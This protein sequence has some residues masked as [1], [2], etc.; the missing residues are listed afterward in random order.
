MISAFTN[1]F[2]IP[3]LRQR[4]LFTL[5]MIVIVRAGSAITTPGVNAE[6][7]REWFRNVADA[8]SAGGVA[9]LFNL[10]SGGALAHCAIFSL[11]IMPYISASIMMQL[12]TAVIPQLGKL[13][14]EDGGRR[15]IMQYTR[16][17]TIAL[18]I[19][20][21]FLLAKSFENPQA[22]PFL[23][24]IMDT[25]NRL[26]MDL[27]PEPGLAFQLMTVITMTAG[28]MFLMWLGDQI[29]ER[30]IGNGVSLI[31]TVG[32]LAQLPAGL[33]QAWRTFVPTAPGAQANVSPIVLVLLCLFL[34]LVIAA[35]IAVTQAQRKISIQYAK[36]VVGRKVYGGQT[37][38]MP[39]K[40]NYAGVMPIIFAQAI[41]LFPSTIINMAFPQNRTA[42]EIANLLAVGW[43]HYVLYGV[44]IFFFSYF[45][46]A[47]QFQP[48]QIADDLKKYGGFIPGVRPG[49]P[50]A[51]FLDY[52]MSRLTFAGAI[53]LT[54]IA[55][56]PQL[57]AQA[58]KVPY[59][60]AQFF[61]GTGVLI[62][63]GV[64]L[65]TMRQVETHLLQRHYDGFLRKG[66]IRGAR[67]QRPR[68]SS[69]QVL[70]DS[71]LVF[72]YASLGILVIAGV[73]IF[74]ATRQ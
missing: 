57:L 58:L 66:K 22:N 51:D 70:D 44:M 34:V 9:S 73:T 4:V 41:L 18:C 33:I 64:V 20:Q 48:V 35:V 69:G 61:G 23:P 55:V 16:Y 32:I 1:I 17:A 26:G 53:F 46:V 19:F 45:W 72:I 38:Y 74:F 30:G 12:L 25:I 3:E 21:G 24:G 11:G 27:V 7:L 63:V 54:I 2:K 29:T 28:T 50:T 56:M 8:Q 49:K 10:F 5:A 52:T 59:M 65:D 6:I 71:S 40:I 62:I 15:K 36:R 37:Q 31:I 60:T 42:Q 39:L 47:T 43:L 67:E 68:L 13:A 14:R